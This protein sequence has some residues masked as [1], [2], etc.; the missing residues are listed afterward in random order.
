MQSAGRAEFALALMALVWGASFVMVKQ[1]LDDV[2][3][4]LYMALRFGLAATV[5]AAAFRRRLREPGVCCRAEYMGGA[6]AGLL[7]FA[8]Y[9]FQTSGLRLTTPSKSAFL[10]GLYIVLVP[11]LVT[12]VYR[13]APR[14]PEVAGILIAGAGMGFMTLDNWSLQMNWGDSL[15]LLCAVAFAGHILAV[16]HF[17]P[18]ASFERFTVIQLAVVGAAA[19]STFWWF[20][21]PRL[22]WSTALLT[23][24][25]VTALLATALAFAVQTWAQQRTTPTRTAL[26]FALEPVFAGLTS[27]AVLGEIMTASAFFGAG[28][29]LAGILMVEL[30]PRTSVPHPLR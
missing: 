24:L 2:S 14:L 30:K 17:S 9:F 27:F 22:V 7:L 4:L 23:A 6:V 10:T 12:V 21:V 15:T 20:E 19:G 5:L 29:I 26:I 1:A 25:L 11:F 3:T 13:R 28:L 18:R 8:G 16:G